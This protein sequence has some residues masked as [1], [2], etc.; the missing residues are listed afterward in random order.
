MTDGHPERQ[1]QLLTIMTPRLGAEINSW[2]EIFAGHLPLLI[3]NQQHESTDSFQKDSVREMIMCGVNP[4]QI[5]SR[6]QQSLIMFFCIMKI[7]VPRPVLYSLKCMVKILLF[8]VLVCWLLALDT[9]R[10]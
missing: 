10:C 2:S 5:M 6:P 8:K 7:Y 9:M 4:W 3:C 1:S